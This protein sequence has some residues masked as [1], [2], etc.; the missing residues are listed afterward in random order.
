MSDTPFIAGL[1]LLLVLTAAATF[2]FVTYSPGATFAGFNENNGQRTHRMPTHTL[3]S[4]SVSFYI[5]AHRGAKSDYPENTPRTRHR[6]DETVRLR[7]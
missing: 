4:D 6:D 5:I 3:F 1:V 7:P 2:V